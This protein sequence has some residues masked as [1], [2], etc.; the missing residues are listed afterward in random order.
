MTRMTTL[1]AAAGCL[2]LAVPATAHEWSELSETISTPAESIT[3]GPAPPM[4]PEGAEIAVLE[5]DLAAEEPHTFRFRMPDGYEIPPHSHP[6]REHITVLDGTL[7]MGH[8]ATY[9]EGAMQALPTGAFYVLPTGD[10]HYIRAD[11]QTVLQLHGIG[12]WGIDYVD[13]EDDPRATQ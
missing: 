12:P 4:L 11:G 7:M 2:T 3:W 1:A 8:G 10:N 5:G 6:M 13:P 9:D